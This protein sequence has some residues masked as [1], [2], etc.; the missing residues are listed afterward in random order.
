MPHTLMRYIL[1]PVLLIVMIFSG[2]SKQAGISD[3]DRS[4]YRSALEAGLRPSVIAATEQTIADALYGSSGSNAQIVQRVQS[5]FAQNISSSA[6]RLSSL[7]PEGINP[8]IVKMAGDMKIARLKQLSIVPGIR[9]PDVRGAAL[10]FIGKLLVNQLSSK[11]SNESDA[12]MRE[13]FRSSVQSAG[14][15]VSNYTQSVEAY[16]QLEKVILNRPTTCME[17]LG[18]AAASDIPTASQIF[19][20]IITEQEERC[21]RTRMSLSPDLL[22]KSLVGCTYDSYTFEPGEMT[23]LKVISQETRG[24]CFVSDIE[25]SLIGNRSKKSYSFRIKTVHAVYLD[26]SFVLI[27]IK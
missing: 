15:Y 26:G 21:T 23:A 3:K 20:E 6:N 11:D 24:H 1:A 17:A 25:I 18:G 10:E 8:E 2:C 4:Y 9:E 14:T 7:K 5:S 22:Y 27:F 19:S 12:R 16:A 13:L